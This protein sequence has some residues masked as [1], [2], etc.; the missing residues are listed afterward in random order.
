[1]RVLK[2]LNEEDGITVIHITHHMDEAN[3][4]DRV[5]IIDAGKIVLDGPPK[6][7]FS[8]AEK[9]KE[10]GLDVPQVTELFNELKKEGFQLPDGVLSVDEAFNVLADILAKKP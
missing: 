3:M 8:N 9:V 4:A 5:I 1:M 6:E 2:K 10:L 7:V